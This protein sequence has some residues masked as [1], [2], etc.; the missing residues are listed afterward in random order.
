MIEQQGPPLEL[1]ERPATRFVAGFL[2]SP[3]MNFV[4]C[5]LEL[6]DARFRTAELPRPRLPLAPRSRAGAAAR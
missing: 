4:P 3:Q 2:G 1:F 5:R 6:R